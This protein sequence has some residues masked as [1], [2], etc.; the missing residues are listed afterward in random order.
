MPL[1]LKMTVNPSATRL[2]TEPTA[3]PAMTNWNSVGT[4]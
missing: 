2:Y 1:A 4:S 3:S